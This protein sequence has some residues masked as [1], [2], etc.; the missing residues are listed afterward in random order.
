MSSAA[1][2]TSA[3]WKAFSSATVLS[4]SWMIATSLSPAA[5][6][7]AVV[8]S[9]GRLNQSGSRAVAIC[10]SSDKSKLLVRLMYRDG[11]TYT[12]NEKPM[13]NLGDITQGFHTFV[14]TYTSGA[15]NHGTLKF[16]WDGVSKL[17]HTYSQDTK[18]FGIP[19]SPGGIQFN[20]LVSRSSTTTG[21]GTF[22]YKTASTPFTT[23]VSTAE[24]LLLQT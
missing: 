11:S 22:V 8:F 15:N 9:V 2:T 5:V 23:S 17:T 12:C 19:S 3:S 6:N 24:I 1:T 10:T 18:W 21:S 16:Y 4:N 20:Q 14:I 13:T 7:N